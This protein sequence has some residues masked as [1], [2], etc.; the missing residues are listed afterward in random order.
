MDP[1][2]DI[3]IEEDGWLDVLPDVVSVVETGI[4][5]ALKA[6]KFGEQ[7]DIV[8]LLCNDADQCVVL[9]S[10]KIHAN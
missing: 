10:S 1:L 5:A 2:I 8:V 7:A 3:E 9:S 4:S 6:A